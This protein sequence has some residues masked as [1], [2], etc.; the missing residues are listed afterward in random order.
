MDILISNE[1]IEIFILNKQTYPKIMYSV[2]TQ[3]NTCTTDDVFKC[4]DMCSRQPAS[5]LD[6]T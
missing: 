6:K 1:N 4:R 2:N 5:K 3:E